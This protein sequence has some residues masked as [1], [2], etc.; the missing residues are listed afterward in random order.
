MDNHTTTGEPRAMAAT[1]IEVGNMISEAEA[2]RASDPGLALAMTEQAITR[3]RSAGLDQSREMALVLLLRCRI[4]T[5]LSNYTDALKAGTEARH[6]AEAAHDT[7]LIKSAAL[8]V[9]TI[10]GYQGIYDEALSYMHSAINLHQENCNTPDDLIWLARSLNSLGYTYVLMNDAKSA[11][12]HLKRSLAIMRVT[13]DKEIKS[14]VLDSLCCAYLSLD[15]PNQALVY[16][17]EAQQLATANHHLSVMAVAAAHTAKIYIAMQEYEL[18][19]Q[20][21]EQAL[22]LAHDN[23][24]L[25]IEAQIYHLYADL[26]RV[27]GNADASYDWLNRALTVA[28][29]IDRKH[30]IADLLGDIARYYKEKRD[31]DQA[32]NYTEQYHEARQA[33]ASEQSTWRLKNLE[34][35]YDVAQIKRENEL[36]HQKNSALQNEIRNRQLSEYSVKLEEQVQVRTNELKLSNQQLKSALLNIEHKQHELAHAARMAAMGSMVVGIAHELNTPVGNCVLVASTLDDHTKR[37][38][39]LIRSNTMRRSD[40]VSFIDTSEQSIGMLTKNLNTAVRLVNNFKQLAITRDNEDRRSFLLRQLTADIMAEHQKRQHEVAVEL[41]WEIPQD[42]ILASYPRALSQVMELMI[43]NAETHAYEHVAHPRLT[44]R[45]GSSAELVEIAFI[46]NG[47]G[48]SEQLM[49]HIFDPFFTTKLGH[50]SNGLGLT[51]VFNLVRNV[52][53]GEVKVSSRLGVGSTF[54]VTIPRVVD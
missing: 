15:N 33:Y 13:P 23:Q 40:L 35:A 38:G 26:E 53:G 46:D 36:M 49:T 31:F 2:K 54:T 30:H 17:L 39:E 51:I 37:M 18:A 16:A 10:Y 45:A 41:A 4:Q 52:L 6:V 44:I 25:L 47:V 9:A 50:G 22:K 48:M 7:S 32:L 24:F 43:D 29:K 8:A 1:L 14:R 20:F 11:L 3:A 42:L 12:P 19:A 5:E 21:L 27:Q 34:I 28:R